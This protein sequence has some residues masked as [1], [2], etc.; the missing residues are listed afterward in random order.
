MATARTKQET[1]GKLL[2]NMFAK[3]L[4]YPL[5]RARHKEERFF[6]L[7]FWSSGA[8]QEIRRWNTRHTKDTPRQAKVTH[9]MIGENLFLFLVSGTVSGLHIYTEPSGTRR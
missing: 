4:V 5:A 8:R 9:P 6:P 2:V 7:R 3:K 1:G